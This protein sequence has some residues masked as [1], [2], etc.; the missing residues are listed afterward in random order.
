MKG[1]ITA[2]VSFVMAIALMVTMMAVSAL[3]V[4]MALVAAKWLGLL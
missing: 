1:A 3:P 4:V 2:V